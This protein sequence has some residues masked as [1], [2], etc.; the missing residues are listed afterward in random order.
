MLLNL[1]KSHQ[2]PQRAPQLRICEGNTV[3]IIVYIKTFLF[4]TWQLSGQSK[5]LVGD[6]VVLSLI[7]GKE[8]S[9]LKCGH[10]E[11][12]ATKVIDKRDCAIAHVMIPLQ[13]TAGMLFLIELLNIGNI[14]LQFDGQRNRDAL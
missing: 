14:V 4:P 8:H 5:I 3:V 11:I 1:G 7:P 10:I 12:V 9:H 13:F 2:R 6:L